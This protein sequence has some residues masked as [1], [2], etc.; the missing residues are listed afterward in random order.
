VLL[1][2]FRASAVGSVLAGLLILG[3]RA[4]GK[5]LQS[6][7]PSLWS[8]SLLEFLSRLGLTWLAGGIIVLV[9]LWS[10]R[11]AEKETGGPISA[12]TVRAKRWGSARAEG[13][14]SLMPVFLALLASL[15]LLS[16]GP[17]L[18]WWREGLALI[19]RLGLWQA[20]GQGLLETILSLFP[21]FGVLFVPVVASAAL[22]S[23]VCGA[24][25]AAVFRKQGTRFLRVYA[26]WLA[27]HAGLVLAVVFAADALGTMADAWLNELNAIDT[28][29]LEAAREADILETAAYLRDWIPGKVALTISLAKRVTW[30]SLLCAAWLPMLLFAWRARSGP[31]RA[32]RS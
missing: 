14:T 5:E 6:S 25:T 24:A 3:V 27:I 32:V 28:A 7:E 16:S 13:L 18:A 19:E 11:S 2:G 17:V 22:L 30:M 31:G 8:V 9:L 20:F 12:Q 15:A 4:L 26:A 1:F 29:G 21:I 10:V 23:F